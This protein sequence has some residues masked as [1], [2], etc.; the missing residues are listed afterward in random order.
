MNLP[1]DSQCM[2]YVTLLVLERSELE[3]ELLL[4]HRHGGPDDCT[5]QTITKGNTI[6][7]LCQ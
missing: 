3:E 7:L 2:A 4:H 5:S 6:E 1:E